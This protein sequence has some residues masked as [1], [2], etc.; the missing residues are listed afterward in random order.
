MQLTAANTYSGN[1]TISGGTLK[2]TGTVWLY[3]GGQ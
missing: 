3:T 1:T 2:V